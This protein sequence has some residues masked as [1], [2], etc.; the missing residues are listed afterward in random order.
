M[1]NQPRPVR[2][3]STHGLAPD[4]LH[5]MAGLPGSARPRV[6]AGVGVSRLATSD[7][8]ARATASGAS[9]SRSAGA[10]AVCLL[11]GL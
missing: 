7:N 9:A 8:R 2:E 11:R 6:P 3:P 4:T 10:K 1:V 5:S